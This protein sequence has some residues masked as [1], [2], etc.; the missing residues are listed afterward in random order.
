MNPYGGIRMVESSLEAYG[1]NM[2]YELN[3]VFHKYRKT[4]NEGVFDVYTPEIKNVSY[5]E[6][7]AI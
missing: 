2:H 6:Q 5:L 1:R 4:H 3:E 7:G